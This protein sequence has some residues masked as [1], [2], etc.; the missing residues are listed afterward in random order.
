[1]KECVWPSSERVA[2]ES[3]RVSTFDPFSRAVLWCESISV[4]ASPNV[5]FLKQ[6]RLS[7]GLAAVC[8]SVLFEIIFR[9]FVQQG[10][11]GIVG[12][13]FLQQERAIVGKREVPEIKLP[14]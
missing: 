4:R 6:R 10:S 5:K 11:T 7:Q 9:K 2:K 13:S 8:A 14:V 3:Q 12:A 1:M